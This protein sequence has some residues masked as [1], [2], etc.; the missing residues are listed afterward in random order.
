MPAVKKTTDFFKNQRQSVWKILSAFL[1]F[2]LFACLE[3]PDSPEIFNRTPTVSICAVQRDST[4]VQPLQVSPSDSFLLDA[5]VSEFKDDLKFQWVQAPKKILS[6]APRFATESSCVPDSLLIFD[7][8]GNRLSFPVSFLFD[9]A[10]ILDSQTVPAEG[11]TL[12]GSATEAFFFS[13]SAS[14]V[15]EDSLFYTVVFDSLEFFAGTLTEIFQSGFTPGWHS[16]RIFVKDSYGLADS[17]DVI[18]FFVEDEK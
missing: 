15:D 7:T 6:E 3:T 10:P 13:Y 18:R 4:C 12:R 5:H 1:P 8:M 17:S 11:D 16:F 2:F 9:S 14:D